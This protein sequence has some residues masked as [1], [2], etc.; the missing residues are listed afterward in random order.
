M[1]ILW[2]GSLNPTPQSHG[3]TGTAPSPTGTQCSVCFTQGGTNLVTI[4]STVPV[5]EFKVVGPLT[6]EN[7]LRAAEAIKRA[8]DELRAACEAQ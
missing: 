7:C 8:Q 1:L 2:I 4:P 5:L 6:Q 3:I